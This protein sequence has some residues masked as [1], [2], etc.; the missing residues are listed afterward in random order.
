M[1]W[2]SVRPA[3]QNGLLAG[4]D[5][6]R[7]YFVHSFHVEC[8]DSSD[9]IATSHHGY[10]FSCAVHRDNIWGTQFHPE[11]SHRFGKQLLKNFAEM[12]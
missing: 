10:D 7:F 3:K 12:D 11:K 9:V 1:G 6:S 4:L 8:E 2:N 5:K